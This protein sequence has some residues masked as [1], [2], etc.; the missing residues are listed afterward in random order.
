LS[1]DAPTI[2]F[3]SFGGG[4]FASSWR[5]GGYVKTVVAT[6]L[7]EV[8]D[9]LSQVEQSAADGLYAAGFVAYEAASALNPDLPS[10]PPVEGLPL[11]WFAIFRERGQTIV[12]GLHSS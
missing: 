9:V 12:S 6:R 2:L 11:A 7:A 5:F 4:R 8:L 1:L 3:D 10:A